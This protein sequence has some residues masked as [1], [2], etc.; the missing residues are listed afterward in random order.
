[1]LVGF[2]VALPAPAQE[3]AGGP[4]ANAKAA[5]SMPAKAK[6]ARAIGRAEVRASRPKREIVGLRTR[7]S[8][9]FETRSGERVARLYSGAVHFRDKR[10]RWRDIDSR[11]R[12]SGG[13]LLSQGNSFHTSLPSDIARDS[14]RVRRGAY[15][16]S[17]KL[18]G[19]RGQARVKDNRA[20]YLNALEGV[21]V[22]YR[23]LGDSLKEELV[24]RGPEA[25]REIVYDLEATRGLRPDALPS[26]AVLLRTSSGSPKLSLPAPFMIDADGRTMRVRVKLAKVKA[27]WRLSYSLS[28]RWLD[29][30]SR[31]WPVVVDPGVL[32]TADRDCGLDSSQPDSS[33]CAATQMKLGR[34]GGV[35]HNVIM[36][37]PLTAIPRGAEVKGAT[38][39]AMVSQDQTGTYTKVSAEPLTQEWSAA[40][41]WKRNDGADRWSEP[42]GESDAD[43]AAEH[44]GY[45][46]ANGENYWTMFKMVR[47]WASGKRPNHGVVLRVPDADNGAYLNSVEHASNKPYLNVTYRERAGMK[48]GWVAERQQISDRISLG[49][50]VGSGNLQ[51]SQ[52]DFSMPGGLGPDVSVGRTYNSMDDELGSF[53]KW[54]MDTGKDFKIV[55]VAGRAFMIVHFPGGATAS[56]ER[57]SD[58]TYKTPAGY[59]NTLVFN[60]PAAG[61][62]TLT[63]HASQ[64]KYIFADNA[65]FGRIKKITD[66]NDRSLTFEYSTTD[67]YLD[68][69]ESAHTNL[70]DNT[71]ETRFTRS[72]QKVTQ[73]TDP[74]GRTYAYAYTGDNLISYQDPQNGASFKTLYEYNGPNGT[75]SKITTPQGNVATVSYFP[76]GHEHFGRVKTVTRVTDTVNQ[77]GP[78]TS[79]EYHFKKDGSG[80]A[81]V[82]D[83]IGTASTDTNDRVTRHEFDDQGRVTRTIDALGRETSRKLTTNSNVESYTA[84]GNTG[85]TPNTSF[86]YEQGTDNLTATSTPT[87]AQGADPMTTS[88]SYGQSGSVNANTPGSEYLPTQS[89]NEQGGVGTIEY[90][91][92]DSQSGLPDTN[93]NP[94]G[95]K[96]FRADGTT[97]VAGVSMQYRPLT[98]TDPVNDPVAIDG[99]RGQLK[100]ITDGRGKLTKYGYDTKGNVTSIDPPGS[101]ANQL[102][103]TSITHDQN[104][105]RVSNVTDG[106]GNKRALFYDSLD[107]LIRIEFTG[108][109]TT[110]AATEPKVEYTYDRDGNQTSEITREEG[111]GTSRTRSM[112]YDKLNR[113]TYESLPGGASNTMTY[114]LVGNLRSL[115]DAGGKVEYTYDAVN[116]Q[117]AVYEPGTT[118]PTKFEHDKDGLR[119]K[120]TYPNGVTV[121]WGYDPAHRMTSIKATNASQTVLQ[122]LA[123]KYRQ[124]A[125]PNRQ[126]PLRYEAEDKVLGRRT[127][128]EYDGLDRLIDATTKTA[129]GTD[130]DG[131]WN[132]ASSIA[133]YLYGLDGAGNITQRTVG[134]SG[135]TANT[136][137]YAYDE[138]NQLCWRSPT[139]GAT[140]PGTA[141]TTSRQTGF[142][143][144]GNE[145]T[146]ATGTNRTAAYHLTDQTK[147]LTISGSPTSLI[148]LGAGQDRWITEGSGSFQHNVLGTGS[149][150]VGAGSDY[151]TRDEVGSLVSRRNGTA[152]HYYLFDAL[153]SVTGLVDSAGTVAERYDYEPYG[154]RDMSATGATASADVAQGQFG[155]AGGYRSAGGLYHYGQRF[156]DP[157]TMRWTQADPLDQTGDLREGNRYVY[158]AA[159]P[160]G[161]SDESG[162]AVWFVP[163]AA[164]AVRTAAVA[165][166]ARQAA[167]A[168]RVTTATVADVAATRTAAAVSRFSAGAAGRII[169]RGQ[170]FK[171]N[172]PVLSRT[173]GEV[174]KAYRRSRGME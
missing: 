138:A 99:K 66:R 13:R 164:L 75:L 111:T 42:G 83:P 32:P 62:F 19:A 165:Y 1:M 61:E 52:T 133:S 156:Y 116:Q 29:S 81:D 54:S 12:R 87:T 141:C 95:I 147:T 150:T 92:T 68:G 137:N 16:V 124:P 149:R 161:L 60:Q 18:R 128:Y 118:R 36:R 77:T 51:V 169:N 2:A 28:D 132:G 38:L 121:D 113:V 112:T 154:A 123:Y 7:T 73:M 27:G 74:A 135:L 96:S 158:A 49:V 23:A 172:H 146:G 8:K 108:A 153:G 6:R 76:S 37:F 63:D 140:V 26:G 100:S 151:F 148:Y 127:R 97:L 145:T 166:R 91:G 101:G 78:T 9:T 115:T 21:D 47:E 142:D 5:S 126:T 69:I 43:A 98:T 50:N 170:S 14:V 25:Q 130:T 107:R 80:Y 65:N 106:K 139:S 71:D 174:F 56:Y 39:V 94:Y 70:S 79:F 85:T 20:R 160:V 93:G 57:Q 64:T 34:I 72:G 89:V 90:N 15:G 152:R 58:G 144:N 143:G 134:G 33:F 10:G 110:L 82:T 84:A 109:D 22:V 31:A 120:T 53:G 104:L 136:T 119:K 24:L 173:V 40:A 105:A 44:P 4:S 86:T 162:E 159:D 167:Q 41:T 67:G 102:G 103:T 114:D 55:Q 163:A 117:R 171:K 129:T 122:E 157:A 46:G 11:L 131:G 125:S 45:L 48:R 59:N 3:R 88:G 17:L 35:D 155:F 30:A 168:A